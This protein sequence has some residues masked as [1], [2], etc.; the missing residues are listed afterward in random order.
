MMN[1]QDKG[2]GYCDKGLDFYRF[3]HLPSFRGNDHVLQCTSHYRSYEDL[4][5]VF[6][7]IS[8][9]LHA[10][11]MRFLFRNFGSISD[12][13]DNYTKIAGKRATSCAA[14]PF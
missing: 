12:F 11:P 3:L 13:K 9:F 8:D 7:S 6:I 14:I 5:F 10:G 4:V 1:L 2:C